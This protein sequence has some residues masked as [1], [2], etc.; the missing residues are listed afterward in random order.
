V[1]TTEQKSSLQKEI[2]SIPAFRGAGIQVMTDGSRE[3]I[4]DSGH[5]SGL[6]TWIVIESVSRGTS[7]GAQA[8]GE[9]APGTT[10][11]IVPELVAAGLNCG[12][13][14]L[15]AFAEGG[16]VLSAVP[17][18][19][20]SVGLLLVTATAASAVS[21]QCGASLTRLA[22][23]MENVKASDYS[24]FAPENNK[25]LDSNEWYTRTATV[26]DAIGLIDGARGLGEG[27]KGA[28]QWRKA[29]D[30]GK[31]Y[32][33][34]LKPLKR[35]ERKRLTEEIGMFVSGASSRGQYKNLVRTGKLQKVLTQK[36]IDKLLRERLYN[37]VAGALGW[38]GSA[39]PKNVSSN[40]GLVNEAYNHAVYV[41]QEK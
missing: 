23:S 40:T 28:L 29:T 12:A 5:A 27:L 18:G 25:E 17:T 36:Q 14:A 26:L 7:K 41:Y 9:A 19:G 13:F 2:D 38:I 11:R 37:G 8:G 31:S 1:L 16:E 6:K 33:E 15:T 10:K 35:E 22:N 34:Y 20:A 3:T 32:L 39:L 4:R 30:T 21:L 24:I